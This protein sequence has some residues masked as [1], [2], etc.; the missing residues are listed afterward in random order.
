[1]VTNIESEKQLQSVLTKG[2]VVIDFWAPWCGP[3]RIVSP[4]VEQIAED[5]PEVKVFK[6]DVDEVRVVE[7]FDI[8]SIPAIIRFSEG[9]EVARFIGVARKDQIIEGLNLSQS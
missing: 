6:L 1:M 2:D 7:D 3:C 8:L 5:H 9:Q 4:I